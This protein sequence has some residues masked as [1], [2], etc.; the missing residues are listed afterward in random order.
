MNDDHKTEQEK[1]K[2]IVESHHQAITCLI[3]LMR[4]RIEMEAEFWGSLKKSLEG[5]K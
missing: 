1:L 5:V 4:K 3:C 2:E